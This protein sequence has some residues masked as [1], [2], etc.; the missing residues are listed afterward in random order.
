[1]ESL[2][3]VGLFLF[4]KILDIIGV[5]FFFVYFVIRDTLKGISYFI[6]GAIGLYISLG[7][8]GLFLCLVLSKI[9]HI[10]LGH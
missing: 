8:I 4:G 9:C 7:I 10:L 2:K 5:S 3:K 1:M 6:I